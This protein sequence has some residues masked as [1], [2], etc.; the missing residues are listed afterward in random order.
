MLILF[1]FLALA[2]PQPFE[3]RQCAMCHRETPPPDTASRYQKSLG[4][5]APGALWPASAMARADRDP[6]WIAK[7]AAE[8]K[9]NPHAVQL[10]DETCSRC[11]S[12]IGSLKG[13]GVAC[14]TCHRLEP[15]G[16]LVVTSKPVAYGPHKDLK[17][18][19]MQHHTGLTPTSSAHVNSSDLCGNCHL[20]KTPILDAQGRKTGEFVEQGTYLEWQESPLAKEGIECRHCHMPRLEND[21]GEALAQYVAHRP[22]GG[23]FPFLDKRSPYGLH[24]FAGANLEILDSVPSQPHQKEAVAAMLR[25]AAQLHVDVAGGEILI[26]FTNL[27][28]HKLPTGFP[29]RSVTVKC[30]ATAA[31]RTV[32]CG[33]HVYETTWKG[34][35]LLR[36]Q[37]YEKDNRL[38]PREGETFH[39]RLPKAATRVRAFALY[40]GFPDSK[41]FELATAEWPGA[42][43]ST[44]MKLSS[45]L[46]PL[47]GAASVR[48]WFPHGPG[49]EAQS[50]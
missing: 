17:G 23:P 26:R 50:L 49:L 12:P 5:I 19:P 21:R 47:A 20:V 9:L 15:S 18:W 36:V 46:I 1:A 38:K 29:T 33:Q 7:V 30:E 13:E 35:S 28:G 22:P 41:P 42:I 14:A 27:A 37:A 10:I 16:G 45:L 3:W 39:F 8:K 25:R 4:A 34:A 43:E 48:R 40:R 31:G 44:D 2:V 32:D 11:H 6:R 24:L